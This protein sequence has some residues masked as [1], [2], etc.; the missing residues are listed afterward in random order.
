LELNGASLKLRFDAAGRL[1]T[2]IPPQPATKQR[3]WPRIHLHN[4]TV[5]IQQLGRP[6]FTV[7][8]VEA[9]LEPGQETLAARGTVSDPYWGNWTLC[10]KIDPQTGRGESLLATDRADVSMAKLRAIPFISTNV[11][12][13]VQ[14]D[15]QT[16]VQFRMVF[17]PAAGSWKYRAEMHPEQAKVYVKA[18]A[19][20]SDRVEGSVIVE[21]GLVTLKELHGMT[22]DGG[23]GTNAQLDFRKALREMTFSITVNRVD[24]RRLPKSWHLPVLFGGR[25]T[26]NALLQ[27]TVGGEPHVLTTGEGKGRLNDT[28]PVRMFANATGFHFSL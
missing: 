23:I 11:W 16:T 28:L 10:G 22:A 2:R 3:T 1:L 27:V 12:E 21:D 25:L 19:L 6:E 7:Q 20:Q 15:A 8:G 13:Q 4:C 5:A 24:T 17:D 26:G 18:I 9:L 14:V